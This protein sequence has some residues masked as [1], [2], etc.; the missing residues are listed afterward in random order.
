ML[1]DNTVKLDFGAG[2]LCFFAIFC[3]IEM[4]STI[5][6]SLDS[7]IFQIVLPNS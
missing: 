3:Y 7:G 5:I 6:L 2:F 4:M 1:S